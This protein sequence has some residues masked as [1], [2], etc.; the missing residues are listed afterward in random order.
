MISFYFIYKDYN[1]GLYKVVYSSRPKSMYETDKMY[2][3]FSLEK[4]KVYYIPKH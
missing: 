1:L 4:N 2:N 3:I